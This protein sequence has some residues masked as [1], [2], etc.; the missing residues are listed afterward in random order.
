MDNT[1]LHAPVVRIVQHFVKAAVLATHN[2]NSV[3]KYNKCRNLDHQKTAYLYP[4]RDKLSSTLFMCK[5]TLVLVKE[6]NNNS[7]WYI[8]P[9]EMN[10][11]NHLSYYL[12]M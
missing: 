7:G 2:C 6:L 3:N 11:Q 4:I 12:V 8:N 5:A 9:I 1:E 10:I